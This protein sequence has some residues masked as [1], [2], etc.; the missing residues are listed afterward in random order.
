L[1][2]SSWV[3]VWQPEIAIISIAESFNLRQESF[4]D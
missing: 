3:V 2:N 1:G 4:I